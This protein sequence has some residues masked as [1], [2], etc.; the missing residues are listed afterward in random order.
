MSCRRDLP[1]WT[2]PQSM[3][4]WPWPPGATSP[5]T[6]LLELPLGWSAIGP[7]EWPYGAVPSVISDSDWGSEGEFEIGR[8]GAPKG[9]RKGGLR[10][11]ST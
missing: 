6:H 4:V 8:F 3:F 9:I 7:A 2:I 1:P 11:G 10:R 5:P